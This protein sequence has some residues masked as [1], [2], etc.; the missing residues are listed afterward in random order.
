MVDLDRIVPLAPGGTATPLFCVHAS[1]GSAWSYLG[2]ARLLGEGRPVFGI[3]APG[4]DGN[5]EPVRSLPALSAE[6]AR[7]LREFRHG[8]EVALLGWSLGGIIA[9]DTA[10]RLTRAGTRVRTVV[11]VDV[12]VPRIA[13][14][15]PEREIVRWFLH[16][17]LASVGADPV[18][19]DRVLAGMPADAGAEE[20]FR[21]AE[22]AA[23]LPAELD[24]DLLAE[25]YPMFRAHLEASYG[26]EVTQPYDGPVV[27]LIASE[28]P[29]SAMRWNTVASN[30]TEHIVPGT[31]YSIWTGHTL[32]KVARL[33]RA[34]LEA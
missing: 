6:Y 7:I 2:L 26:F 10:R 1:S 19:P 13:E 33:V 17:V 27:H 22:R 34:A 32:P 14:L 15:P 4:F 28:S 24:A 31:H 5:R 9:L 20:V 21:A 18:T 3:E 25:R 23:A 8:G 30:L 11:M 16:N 12:S 29:W